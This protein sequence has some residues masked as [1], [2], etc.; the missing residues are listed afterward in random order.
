[1]KALTKQEKYMTIGVIA[2]AVV[3][4]FTA[5]Q[6]GF[7]I[8]LLIAYMLQ[9]SQKE[10]S[11]DGSTKPFSAL[12]E[13]FK[14]PTSYESKNDVKS[15]QCDIDANG[16]YDIEVVGESNY[17]TSI[18]ACIPSE[19]SSD[20]KFR[21]YFIF[22][23]VQEDD[24]EHDKNAV[25]VKLSGVVG[26]LPR[27]MAKKYRTWAYKQELGKLATCRGVIIGN[28]GKDYSIWLDLPI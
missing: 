6:V 2:S 15:I 27:P 14:P 23:L 20:D 3:G 28:K 18:W 17:R 21:L 9:K 1:M 12:R 16:G 5:W 13:L 10:S 11:T 26:Y 22:T 19:H 4:Y 7:M 24:N 25:A 8:A